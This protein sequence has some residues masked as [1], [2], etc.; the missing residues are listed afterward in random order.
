MSFRSTPSDFFVYLVNPL[1]RKID[2]G[3]FQNSDYKNY[4]NGFYFF[5]INFW[6]SLGPS[7]AKKYNKNFKN[8]LSSIAL[9]RAIFVH[10]RAFIT[11]RIFATQIMVIIASQ[12]LIRKWIHL[13]FDY[14]WFYHTKM[15][16]KWVE[17]FCWTKKKR[18]SWLGRDSN[19]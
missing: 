6:H 5:K 11:Q 9:K 7:E 14:E 8:L 4:P 18:K 12:N 2:Q 15:I 10:V 3:I 16:R 19:R 1:V 13:L 17:N